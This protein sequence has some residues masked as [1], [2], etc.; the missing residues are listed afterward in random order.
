MIVQPDVTI[1]LGDNTEDASNLKKQFPTM[2]LCAVKGNCD[3]MSKHPTLAVLTI[4][5]KRIV[6]TH[7]HSFR[8]KN[9][10]TT[11]MIA[12]KEAGADILLFGHTHTPLCTEYDGMTILNPGTCGKGSH[13]TYG[14]LEFIDNEFTAEIRDIK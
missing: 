4:A 11:L 14:V 13:M 5:G 9:G 8:V 12:G 7:G 10:Y 1:H 3:Y 2:K 6:Y